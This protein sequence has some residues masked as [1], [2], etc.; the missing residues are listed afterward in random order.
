MTTTP[1]QVAAVQSEY[2][3]HKIR[4]YLLDAGYPIDGDAMLAVDAVDDAM[5]VRV[6]KFDDYKGVSIH[7]FTAAGSGDRCISI[8]HPGGDTWVPMCNTR[9]NVLWEM[10]DKMATSA[11]LTAAGMGQPEPA[12]R[13]AVYWMY[14]YGLD[15]E[16]RTDFSRVPFL[17]SWVAAK[18]ATVTKLYASA[19]PVD[20]GHRL[21][22]YV[23]THPYAA[24]GMG[25]NPHAEWVEMQELAR[26]I[27]TGADH[28]R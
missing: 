25:D 13:D 24:R 2:D 12:G 14:E 28:G 1:P 26:A 15:G 17:D 8:R 6:G 9:D 10:L 4:N 7:A 3:L 18:Q 23:M 5:V 19:P 11:A 20:P 16:T 22:S 21:A 27:I